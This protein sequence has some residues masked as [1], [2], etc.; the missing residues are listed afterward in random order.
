[1]KLRYQQWNLE[2]QFNADGTVTFADQT[3]SGVYPQGEWFDVVHSIDL[4][5]GIASVAMVADTS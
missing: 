1:M 3:A 2:T 4:D 5:N